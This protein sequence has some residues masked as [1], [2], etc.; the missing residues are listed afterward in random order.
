MQD[1]IYLEQT[2][3]NFFFD[4]LRLFKNL[5]KINILHKQIFQKVN[6]RQKIISPE[7]FVLDIF[8]MMRRLMIHQSE[9]TLKK[10][11]LFIFIYVFA[12]MD[13]KALIDEGK[14]AFYL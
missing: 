6:Q 12:G 9:E 8:L 10:K 14:L 11:I 13:L 4:H 2:S 5:Q 3:K 7:T 1:Y